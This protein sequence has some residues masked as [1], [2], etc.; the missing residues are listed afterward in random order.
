MVAERCA[1]VALIDCAHIN[2]L[3]PRWFSRRLQAALN[4]NLMAAVRIDRALVPAM[5]EREQGIVLHM[6]SIQKKLPLHE[7]TI[8][9]AAAKA[10]LSNDSK[11]LSKELGPKGIRVNAIAPG[12]INTTASQAMVT[13]LAQWAKR[14]R[15]RQDKE[16]SMHLAASLLVALRGPRGL[17]NWS[18]FWRPI[19][20]LRSTA[21]NT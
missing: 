5:V 18:P 8:A 15:P 17:P 1:R 21:P 11:S 14:M 6:A 9:Y 3:S 10:A 4:L 13:R 16:S 7:S 2:R 19:A 12:W 20:R